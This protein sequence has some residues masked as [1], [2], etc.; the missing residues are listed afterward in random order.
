MTSRFQRA[1]R[2]EQKDARRRA[3]LDA[4]REL[5]REVGPI[6][7]SLNELGRRSGVSKPNIYRYFE[8]REDVLLQLFVAEIEELVAEIE[9][10]LG[11]PRARVGTVA[12]AKKISRAFL[13]RPLAC[14]LLGMVSS[15][16][17]HNL[18]AAAIAASKREV[19]SVS[20]RFAAVL[21]RVMPELSEGEAVWAVM[22]IALYVAGLWPAAHPSAA[23]E[24]ALAAP[25]LSGLRV[26]AEKD[27]PRFVETLLAGLRSGA[28][29]A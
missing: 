6:E 7:L 26:D 3:I 21:V 27:L 18:S 11:K 4:A 9:A 16:I 20:L 8:S 29:E 5:L 14:Q 19:R 24:E 17:E 2:P 28:K 10:E 22:T 12:I 23:A 1:R 13:A 25:E 15:I